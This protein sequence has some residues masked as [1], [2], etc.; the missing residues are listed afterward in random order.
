MTEPPIACDLLI[1]GGLVLTPAGWLSDTSV[2]VHGTR[3]LAIGPRADLAA[4]HAPA[5]RIA[6][7]DRMVIPGL[8]NVHNHTPLMITRGM[9]ED[10]GYAP[11][12]TPGIP[13][14]HMLSAEETYLLARLG[15]YEALRAGSTTMVDFYRAP[16][17]LARAHAEL[18]TRAIIGGRVHDADPAALAEGR[19][20]Y[21]TQI[22]DASL[23]ENADVIARWDGH[24][25]WRIRCDWAP[26]A[27][28][29]CSDA[30]LREVAALAASHGGNIHT[31]LAQSEAEVGAV[32]ART[33]RSSA[34]ALDEAGLLHSRLIAAHCIHLDAGDIARCGRAG[35]TVAHA[36]IGNARS[37]RIAPVMELRE[38]G[39]RITLCTDTMS[40]DMIEAT[41][42][43]VAL[44]RVRA[45][46]RF[47]LDAA[48]T[49]GW[50]TR[51]GAEALGLGAEVGAIEPGRKAD[52]VLLDLRA[53]RL[54]PVVDGTG[55]LVH[56]A[57]GGEVHTVIVDG[58]VVLED[59]HPTLVD[60]EE[61][62]RAA[63]AAAEGL[64]RRAGRHPVTLSA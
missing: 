30:L 28:D 31:H 36:P 8:V 63:Q 50:A 49:L 9:V 56:S 22:G 44:Q 46:G 20:E 55:I 13:Q 6:A 32:R 39:A 48:E 15:A 59:G 54:A 52:L 37:G 62:V 2:A 25:G 21:A 34:E 58:R 23:R 61:V 40:G 42:W 1:E 17:S 60:G 26:H 53:P 12:Y 10:L 33:G 45:D 11:M 38:A 7:G 35:I 47:V 19:H 57:S 64:W 18:G 27:P 16:E 43:A 3:I 14:G 51:A 4:R 41:R 5:R 24:D 29:T